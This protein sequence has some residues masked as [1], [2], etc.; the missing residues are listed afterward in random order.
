MKKQK[1]KKFAIFILILL[2]CT[3]LVSCNKGIESNSLDEY[4]SMVNSSKVGNSSANIDDPEYFLPSVSF[5]QDYQ[6]TE[7]KYYWRQDNYRKGYFGIYVNPEISFLCLQY[8]ETTY[9]NAKEFMLKEIEPYNNKFYEYNDYIFYE[10][11]N[12]I[13]LEAVN[14]TPESEMP[15]IFTMACYNDK[16]HTLIFIGFFSE[17]FFELEAKYIENIEENWMDF[18]DQYFGECYDFQQ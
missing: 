4:I 5:L 2:C 14:Q 15:E 1:I 7:G 8:E 6:Y 18:I 17:I 11:S 9:Y 3:S 13:N 10:N 12:F 16:N